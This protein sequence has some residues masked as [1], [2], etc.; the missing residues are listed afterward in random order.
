MDGRE[1]KDG[2]SR[3]VGDDGGVGDCDKS[4]S[5]DTAAAAQA[6]A[7]ARAAREGSRG[8]EQDDD[9]V[10]HPAILAEGDYP[11]GV[12]VALDPTRAT[13]VKLTVGREVLLL[14]AVDGLVA[15]VGRECHFR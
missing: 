5:D 3:P 8:K 14:G 10:Q 13:V 12:L 6:A 2:E 9:E 11:S 15:S 4:M 1:G 7:A